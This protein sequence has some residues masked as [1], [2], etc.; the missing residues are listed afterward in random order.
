MY[1]LVDD[2][3]NIIVIEGA[4]GLWNDDYE[5]GGID[6]ENF[7]NNWKTQHTIDKINERKLCHFHIGK[8]I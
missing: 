2:N 7:K 5:L 4:G 6:R 3:F 8:Q 1:C